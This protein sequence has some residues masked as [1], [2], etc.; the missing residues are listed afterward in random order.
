MLLSAVKQYYQAIGCHIVVCPQAREQGTSTC[1]KVA[2][3]AHFCQ[4]QQAPPFAQAYRLEP[5]YDPRSGYEVGI[6]HISP[7]S[8]LV[9]PAAILADNSVANVSKL[10]VFKDEEVCSKKKT[11]GL[12]A[13][14]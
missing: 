13:S 8:D 6:S 10:A 12:A 7:V 3:C 1:S 2:F 11:L 4:Q 9:D 5:L 14:S